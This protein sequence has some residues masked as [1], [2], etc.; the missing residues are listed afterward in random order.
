[1]L[2]RGGLAYRQGKEGPKTVEDHC[3][4]AGRSK[5]NRLLAKQ[6]RLFSYIEGLQAET[7]VYY[8]LL[9]CGPELRIL[10][11]GEAGPAVRCT[12]PADMEC[13]ARNLLQYLYENTV[14]P[15]QAADVLA[16]CCTVGQVEVL[17]AGC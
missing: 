13:R 17:N 7:R 9:Q 3:G 8:T 14:M 4:K 2:R 1:M 6:T 12:F 16:D 10:V 15:S 11:S 5:V